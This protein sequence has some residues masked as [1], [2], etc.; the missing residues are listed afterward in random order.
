[1]HIIVISHRSAKKMDSFIFDIW[2]LEKIL[3][4]PVKESKKLDLYCRHMSEVPEGVDMRQYNT[5]R[6]QFN[7][8]KYRV[9][10]IS[11][12]L[13]NMD[14]SL[15]PKEVSQNCLLFMLLLFME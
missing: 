8:F 3:S 15:N 14:R 6:A 13:H 1:M 5:R 4:S 7:Q 2:F 12:S 9:V 11:M 10:V